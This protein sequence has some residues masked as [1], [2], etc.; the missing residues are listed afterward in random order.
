MKLRILAETSPGEVRVAVTDGDR[1]LDYA[2]WRPAAPDGVGDLHRGRVAA[3]VPAMAGAF[4][5][6]ADGQTG[7]LPDSQGGAA[8]TEGTVLPVRVVRAAQGSK[9]PRLTAL[10]TEAEAALAPPGPPALLRRGPDPLRRLAAQYPDAP[11]TVD[12]HGL[13]AALRPDLGPRVAVIAPA[14]PDPIAEQAAALAEPWADLPGGA[15][16]SFHPTPALTAI[17]IDAGAATAE[18]A[19]K[20]EAQRALNRAAVAA[21]AAQIR[22][23]NLSGAILLDLA[24]MPAR[25]RAGIGPE[26]AAALSSDPLRPRLLG[27]TALGLAE[28]VRPRIH[29]PLH[30]VLSG[31]HAAAIAALRAAAREGALPGHRPAIRANPAVAAA[32]DRDPEALA[33]LARRLGHPISVTADASMPPTA[34]T[35]EHDPQR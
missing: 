1:L 4:V 6:L 7:F 24:G 27:F 22:L 10:L 17:D 35:L 3:R 34:W 5:A 12:D 14:F 31:P 28:I 11:V 16:A 20:A 25:K 30:E 8:A 32:L 21:V 19:G 18:R 13:A 15:R 2:I 26:L 29:P 9:G 33:A 23:R